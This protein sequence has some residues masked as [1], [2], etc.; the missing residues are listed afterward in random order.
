MEPN[1]AVVGTKYVP[2][3]YSHKVWLER[4]LAV[5]L[6]AATVS[7]IT[8]PLRRTRP[9]TRVNP[10]RGS[11]MW[12]RIG[13][14]RNFLTLLAQWGDPGDCDFDGGGGINDYLTLLDS[15]GP[16]P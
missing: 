6:T 2:G 1:A 3:P 4:R 16:C 5:P 9:R 7:T 15:W 8:R 10:A 12:Y 13:Y 11:N 14:K